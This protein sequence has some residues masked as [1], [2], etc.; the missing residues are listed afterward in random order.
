MVKHS[1]ST[2]MCKLFSLTLKLPFPAFTACSM[3]SNQLLFTLQVRNAG[4][5][6]VWVPGGYMTLRT[7]LLVRDNC[8]GTPA[9][10]GLSGKVTCQQPETNSI[11]LSHTLL[12][13]HWLDSSSAVKENSWKLWRPGEDNHTSIESM[14]LHVHQSAWSKMDHHMLGAK[15]RR[16][17]FN[18]EN[19]IITNCEFF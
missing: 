17:G 15:Y 6:W 18:C 8:C 11:T 1:F 2:L 4:G 10:R 7:R 5:L 9:C 16:T 14:H 13:V 19:L 3:K 12:S